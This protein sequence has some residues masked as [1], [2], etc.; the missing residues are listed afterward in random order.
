MHV[1]INVR[2]VT[3]FSDT[4]RASEPGRGRSLRSQRVG[5]GEVVV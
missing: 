2:F 3:F 4:L 5:M 1:S